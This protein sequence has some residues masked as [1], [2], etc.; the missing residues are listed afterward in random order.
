MFHLYSLKPKKL[1]VMEKVLNPFDPEYM[2]RNLLP[3]CRPPDQSA[4]N[5]AECHVSHRLEMGQAVMIGITASGARGLYLRPGEPS[6]AW[7]AIGR[8]QP[9]LTWSRTGSAS[10]L[11]SR[12]LHTGCL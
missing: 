9:V 5:G 1:S 11:T 8:K 7:G 12:Q 4:F 6:S 3:M 10:I 2:A